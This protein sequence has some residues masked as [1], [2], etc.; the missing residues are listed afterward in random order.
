M[1]KGVADSGAGGVGGA[2][3]GGRTAKELQR[4]IA[5]EWT[6]IA[7]TEPKAGKRAAQSRTVKI[8][9]HD[10]LR[11]SVEEE[12][13][14]ERAQ[15]V[16]AENAAEARDEKAANKFRHQPHCALCRGVDVADAH[17]QGHAQALARERPELTCVRC[18]TTMHVDCTP[19]WSVVQV[20]VNADG[21]KQAVGGW[22]CPHHRCRTCWRTGHEAGGLLF[23]CVSCPSSYCEECLL[24][25][26]EPVPSAKY[27]AELNYTIPR[28]FET[29]RC[30]AC[31]GKQERRRAAAANL[32]AFLR[33]APKW[34]KKSDP[35]AW[36]ASFCHFDESFPAVLRLKLFAKKGKK[37]SKG[38]D[39][40]GANDTPAE[41]SRS[42]EVPPPPPS[43]L[44]PLPVSL[45]YTHSLPRCWRTAI[46]GARWSLS[47]SGAA[48]AGTA[49]Q[50]ARG[51]SGCGTRAGV[52][53]KTSGS[54]RGAGGC[55]SR[56]R[57]R[58]RRGR[59][60]T[61]RGSLRR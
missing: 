36:G 53:S 38:G 35:A 19:G 29:M 1:V 43:L 14:A 45:L 30:E 34:H 2:G 46:G 24:D 21:T 41:E 22:V 49:V 18:P 59:R 8:D 25:G 40:A 33:R 15:R 12:A 16:A 51:C 17:T 23:R 3:A 54:P 55:A 52:R 60:W 47:G 61:R 7:G 10:V 39:D 48:T 31:A 50:R 32:R 5:Q 27:F 11:W 20:R 37:K 57:R 13:A 58:C 6:E 44:L 42:V 28:S 56:S 9:G 4:S 26:F